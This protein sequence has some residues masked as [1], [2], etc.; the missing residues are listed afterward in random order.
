[1]SEPSRLLIIANRIKYELDYYY[2]LN[3]ILIILTNIYI[4]ETEFYFSI[5]ELYKPTNKKERKLKKEKLNELN[6]N[7]SE[8]SKQII[9]LKYEIDKIETRWIIK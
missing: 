4:K 8:H 9:S 7:I 6:R 2:T 3:K 5:E 1:M